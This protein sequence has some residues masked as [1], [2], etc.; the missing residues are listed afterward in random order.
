MKRSLANILTLLIAALIAY[1]AL[2][3]PGG[4]NLTT[5]PASLFDKHQ[6]VTAF[7][8]LVLPLTW[9][10]IRN[11]LWLVP[12]AIVYGGAIELLQPLIGRSGSLVDLAADALGCGLGV[13]PGALRAMLGRRRT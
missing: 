5:G 12:L 4:Y 3:P 13:L 11:A 6:H 2:T 1:G 8:L 10:N 7:A 9:G